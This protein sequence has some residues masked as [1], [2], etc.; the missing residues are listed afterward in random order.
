MHY[1]FVNHTF[2]Y[3]QNMSPERNTAQLTTIMASAEIN[4]SPATT[5]SIAGTRTSD[6]IFTR[7]AGTWTVDALIGMY[8]WSFA[9]GT[10]TVG[11]FLKIAD[12]AADTVTVSAA[13]GAGA[14]QTTGTSVIILAST[15]E[16]EAMQLLEDISSWIKIS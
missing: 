6:V 5:D 1:D 16:A 3:D 13:Y 10:P 11:N 2:D 12:N 14:L 7:S 15:S 8:L 4:P 9:T